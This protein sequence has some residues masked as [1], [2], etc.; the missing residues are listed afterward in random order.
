MI[1]G[2]IP[3][4]HNGLAVI[5]IQKEN[6]HVDYV[7]DAA[8]RGKNLVLTEKWVVDEASGILTGVSITD[9]SWGISAEAGTDRLT[10]FQDALDKAIGK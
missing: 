5:R 9:H 3:L 2:N 1:G 7:D 6:L 10:H 4:G 8:G